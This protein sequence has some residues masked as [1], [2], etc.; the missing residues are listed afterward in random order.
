MFEQLSEKLDAVLRNIR[1][2]GKISEKNIRDTSRE[3]RRALLEADV[4]FE[5][6][7][8]FIKRVEKRALGVT[9]TQSV[10]PG[11]QFVKILNHH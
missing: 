1:G 7:R 5:V 4:H 6:A 9:V 10:K 11:E 8:D 3:V 2:L